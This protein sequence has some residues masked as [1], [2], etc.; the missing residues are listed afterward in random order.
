[1][2]KIAAVS[3]VVALFFIGGCGGSTK[4]KTQDLS[5]HVINTYPACGAG[6]STS[7]N[8]VLKDASGTVVGS[9]RPS[10]TAK[11][12]NSSVCDLTLN[13]PKVPVSKF[14]TVEQDNGVKIVTANESDLQNGVIRIIAG[15][16]Y[17]DARIGIC[18]EASKDGKLHYESPDKSLC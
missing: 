12:F 5:I 2:A 8:L 16:K 6:L 15:S 18:E 1:M 3:V 13:L 11:P 10:L 7:T 9:G 4:A 17:S 14:Y